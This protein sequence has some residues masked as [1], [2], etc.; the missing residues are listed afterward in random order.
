MNNLLEDIKETMELLRKRRMKKVCETDTHLIELNRL[1]SIAQRRYEELQLSENYRKV[2]D[3][4][5]SCMNAVDDYCQ[6]LF[7]SQGIQDG[8]MLAR[9]KNS[10]IEKDQ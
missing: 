4:L 9:L 6:N 10:D 1:E 2:I 7:Y 8:A 3:E 5:I